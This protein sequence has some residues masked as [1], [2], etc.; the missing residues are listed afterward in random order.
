M[1]YNVDFEIASI[2]LLIILIIF[3]NLQY[4]LETSTNQNFRTLLSLALLANFMDVLTAQTIN[5]GNVLPVT[6]NVLLNTGYFFSIAVLGLYF[7]YYFFSYVYEETPL[8]HALMCINLAMFILYSIYLIANIF[9]GFSFSFNAQG[10]YQK[11]TLYFIL[12]IVPYFFILCSVGILLSAWKRFPIRQKMSIIIYLIIGSS[13]TMIQVI[14]LP[15][16]LIS[17]FTV[18]M[19]MIMILFSME[20]PDYQKLMCT[21]KELEVAQQEAEEAKENAMHANVAKSQFLA[22]M[23]HEIRTPIN[24]ILG[25]DEMLLRENLE[26]EQRRFALNIQSAGNS[27]LSIINDILD[28]SKIESGKM[29]IIPVDYDMETLITT[30]YNMVSIRA[31]DKNLTLSVKGD[32]DLP[33]NL[34]GD[35]IRIR[36]IITNILNNAIKYTEQGSID[37][38]VGWKEI[39]K[40]YIS[41]EITVADTGMGIAEENIPHLFSSF[42]RLDEKKNRHIEGTGL[43]LAITKQLL[44]LMDGTITVTSKLGKGSSFHISI[45]QKKNSSVTVGDFFDNVATHMRT[46]T[47]YKRQFTAPNAC[48]LVV[49]DVP[50]NLQVVKGLL[51]QTMLQVD[52]AHSGKEALSMTATKKYSLILMDHMMPELDGIET[53]HLL[54]KEH[55]PNEHTPVIVLTANAISGMREKYLAEGFVDYLTKPIRGEDLEKAIIEHL[56]QEL[57]HIE[58]VKVIHTPKSEAFVNAETPAVSINQKEELYKAADSSTSD[59]TPFQNALDC[60]EWDV[61]LG[62]ADGDENFFKEVIQFYIEEAKESPLQEDFESQDWTSYEIHI[63]ALKGTSKTI[64]AI[65]FHKACLAMEQAVKQKDFQFVQVNQSALMSGYHALVQKLQKYVDA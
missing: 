20:T 32:A 31:F 48:I 64:G 58:Q 23:S 14:F 44:D 43:G 57:L 1:H 21:M 42:Q 16:V 37:F 9:F 7:G 25:M 49:D 40:D 51:K 11:N 28:F 18:S 5:Y 27:L 22:N 45:P 13:G 2:L 46:Y 56:P 50:M 15:N 34:N 30:C 53:L 12:I 38:Q 55:N 8:K 33:K 26:E 24:S 4:N 62:Y 41:L 61:G 59:Q 52:L 19:G 54:K 6:L 39:D 65:A 29:D 35:E 17:M 47:E 36:Q 60:M 3:I 10:E 63:H